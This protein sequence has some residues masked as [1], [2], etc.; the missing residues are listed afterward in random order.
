[1]AGAGDADVAIIGAGAAGLMTAITAARR[2]PSLRVV[3]LEGARR[4]GAKILVSGG[5]RCNV[6]NVAVTA[7]DFHGDRAVIARV[8]KRFGAGDARRFFAGIGVELVVEPEFNKFF[9]VS[10]RARDVLEALLGECDRLGVEL[11]SGWRVEA[12]RRTEVG[13]EL[14]FGSERVVA[15]RLVLATGGRALPKSGSDGH[16][17]VLARSLG[18]AVSATEPALV[19]LCLEPHALR[20]LSGVSFPGEIQVWSGG[21]CRERV[22]GPV[23]IT[24]FGL[25]GP[26]VLD[27]SRHY[28][29]SPPGE[30]ELRLGFLPGVDAGDLEREWVAAARDDGSRQVGRLLAALPGRLGEALLQVVGI[31]RSL[32]VARLDRESRRRLLLAVTSWP[33]PV[34]GTRGF[35][36]AEVTAGGV[37]LS[38][39]DPR[40]MASSRCPGLYLVGE[41]LD[42]DGRIGGFNFQWAWSTGFVAGAALG[43]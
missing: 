29:T 43:S 17:Y 41:V 37:P 7:R 21:R 39:I 34:R 27:A 23:L 22:R 13:F 38:E 24:H 18:H 28:T 4:P 26:A 6:T 16:G 32:T 33:L 9:P 20:D 3:L 2:D 11:R 31:D 35:T 12:V 15:S 1:M 5:G 30:V 25:S 10:N 42:V 14:S 40:T 36:V 19:P 8:L